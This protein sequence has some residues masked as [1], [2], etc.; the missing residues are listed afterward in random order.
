MREGSFNSAN[1]SPARSDEASSIVATIVISLYKRDEM[2][3]LS[4]NSVDK[5]QD[6]YARVF[7]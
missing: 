5:G 6:R 3:Y 1:I 2:L 4:R 7:T